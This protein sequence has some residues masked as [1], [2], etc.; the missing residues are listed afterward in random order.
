MKRTNTVPSPGA[1]NDR[2]ALSNDATPKGRYKSVVLTQ[3]RRGLPSSSTLAPGF[4]HSFGFAKTRSSSETEATESSAES[5][6]QTAS[7][8]DVD[9]NSRSED[10]S[11]SLP[12]LEN[13]F[14]AEKHVDLSESQ[15]NLLSHNLSEIADRI[16][17]SKYDPVTELTDY[18]SSET[19]IEDSLGQA[20]QATFSNSEQSRFKTPYSRRRR[21]S[22]SYVSKQK[23]FTRKRSEGHYSSQQEMN[24]NEEMSV[25]TTNVISLTDNP[26]TF[27]QLDSESDSGYSS[28]MSTSISLSEEIEASKR[29]SLEN[30]SITDIDTDDLAIGGDD[31]VRKIS[32][33][34]SVTNENFTHPPLLHRNSSNL[35]ERLDSLINGVST[36][37]D[38]LNLNAGLATGMDV[39]SQLSLDEPSTSFKLPLIENPGTDQPKVKSKEPS[40]SLTK[41]PFPLRKDKV[42]SDDT[43]L[44]RTK[45]GRRPGLLR[46]RTTLVSFRPPKQMTVQEGESDIVEMDEVGFMQLLTDIK[47]LKTQLLKLKRELQEADVVSPLTHSHSCVVRRSSISVDSDPSLER[48]AMVHRKRMLL[49][50]T[51]TMD[52]TTM[53]EKLNRRSRSSTSSVG[54]EDDSLDDITELSESSRTANHAEPAVAA[55]NEA[56]VEEVKKLREELGEVKNK[57]IDITQERNSLMIA[58]EELEHEL[59]SKNHTIRMLQKQLEAQ[60]NRDEIAYFKRQ[61]KSLTD[62]IQQQQQKITELRYRS[63]SPGPV[64]LGTVPNFQNKKETVK[65]DI[66]N[67]LRDAFVRH[68]G[69][70]SKSHVQLSKHLLKAEQNITMAQKG[71]SSLYSPHA[72]TEHLPKDKSRPSF[73]RSDSQSSVERSQE[74]SDGREYESD[75]SRSSRRGIAPSRTERN[76]EDSG[77]ESRKSG[78]IRRIAHPGASASQEESDG[79]MSD[80]DS[81][82][83]SR[84]RVAS[85]PFD[86]DTEKLNSSDLGLDSGKTG[87]Q[88]EITDTAKA[89]KQNATPS[90]QRTR[91]LSRSKLLSKIESSPLSHSWTPGAI[92]KIVKSWRETK[93]PE[94]QDKTKDDDGSLKPVSHVQFL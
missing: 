8:L 30:G 85:P 57:L 68:L 53:R 86:K 81:G 59:D 72:S 7:T 56:S 12:Q 41:P 34:K 20:S 82:K 39:P 40:D 32:G 49:S 29:L 92:E 65:A 2:Q 24:N 67:R 42:S 44:P 78:R 70:S 48:A 38:E 91:K 60:D 74:D 11:S 22:K 94:A 51:M 36:G 52:S 58:R 17:P 46:R 66:R 37:M 35:G 80:S 87:V 28:S 77:S 75:S 89:S 1:Q 3:G 47:S 61:V 71:L 93:S 79:R 76:S 90:A 5:T 69:E 45:T 10:S 25:D 13:N 21:D 15:L 64:P 83:P 62:Q 14:K 88:I 33:E 19:L 84:R 73:E 31:L 23:S 4:L 50:R 6:Q 27:K 18:E 55:T 43:D 54:E 63:T 9:G 26:E 16:S